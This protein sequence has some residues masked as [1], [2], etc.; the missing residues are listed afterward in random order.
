[1]MAQRRGKMQAKLTI[2]LQKSG[3][4]ADGCMRLFQNSGINITTA[5]NK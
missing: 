1:M 4:L 3:R 2:A 5:K